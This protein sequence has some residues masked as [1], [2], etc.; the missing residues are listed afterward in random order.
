MGLG[1]APVIGVSTIANREF[2]VSP[3]GRQRAG[4]KQAWED[5]GLEDFGGEASGAIWLSKD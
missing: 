1:I 3:Q 5:V 2:S 4:W